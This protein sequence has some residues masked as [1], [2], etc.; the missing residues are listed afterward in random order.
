MTTVERGCGT[1]KVGGVYL[2]VKTGPYGRPLDGFLV[3]PPRAI[4]GAQEVALGLKD[5][6]VTLVKDDRGVTH[7]YDI[8][9]QN[10]YPNVADFL[11]EL[12]RLG[13]SRKVSP[14]LDFSALTPESRL[15]LLHRRAMLHNAADLV[16]RLAEEVTE[17]PALV[18][19]RERE[20]PKAFPHGP[21]T[22]M[23]Q[24]WYYQV[25]EGGEPSLDPSHAPRTVRRT[26]GSTSY[27]AQE[28]PE[29]FTPE[30][31]LAIF[32]VL[33]LSG[34]EVIRDPDDGSHEEPLKKAQASGLPVS[35]EDD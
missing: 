9:G 20:C 30:P 10:H 5:I 4:S 1:R 24:R 21:G 12:R 26:V 14:G 6:G 27:W 22:V 23:C 25:V 11:E 15:V 7:V 3:C 2:M 19:Q 34:I 18:T 33:P 13:A 31:G 8:V 35:L 17:Y 28:A 29:G 16:G 32:G